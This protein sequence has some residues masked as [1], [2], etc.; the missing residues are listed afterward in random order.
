MTKTLCLECYES[1]HPLLPE[2]GSY[3]LVFIEGESYPIIAIW[4]YDESRYEGA[5]HT[6]RATYPM[7]VV[8]CWMHLPEAKDVMDS[9]RRLGAA[10][11]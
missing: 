7:R 1:D 10:V 5:F 2:S 3:C 6:N 8:A 9:R 4:L 11:D